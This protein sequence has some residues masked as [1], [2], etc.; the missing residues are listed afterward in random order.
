MSR[1]ATRSQFDWLLGEVAAWRALGLVDEERAAALLALY[2]SRESFEAR[3][4]STGQFTLMA[5]AALLVG[6]GVLLLIGYNWEQMPAP[7]KVT[8]IF[9]AL[10]ATH[11]AAFGLRYQLGWRRASE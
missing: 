1:E 11:A 7:L 2:E 10:V 9:G 3:Q 5:V 6:L 4:Q 8:A